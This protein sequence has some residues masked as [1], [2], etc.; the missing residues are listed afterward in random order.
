MSDDAELRHELDVYRISGD[1]AQAFR[2]VSPDKIESRV[3]EEFGRR[4]Q[5]PI[6]D[7]V[8]IFVER[9]LRGQLRSP[10]VH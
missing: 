1:L 8:P 5:Y 10:E 2:E 3:R 6:Q 7:F 4:S 9:S